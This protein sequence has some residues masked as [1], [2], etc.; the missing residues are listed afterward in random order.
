MT[1]TR[2]VIA[3]RPDPEWGRGQEIGPRNLRYEGAFNAMVLTLGRADPF[4]RELRECKLIEFLAQNLSK[5][6]ADIGRI[7][8]AIQQKQFKDLDPG[9]KQ[10]V[11]DH[12]GVDEGSTSPFLP[13]STI[14]V[15]EVDERDLSSGTT[16]FSVIVPSSPP[17]VIGMKAFSEKF[18]DH[19]E[20]LAQAS[21]HLQ[22]KISDA[23][24]AG[25]V[26][27]FPPQA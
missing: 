26:R 25:R 21:V 18:P 13:T 16:I 15:K 19:G 22:N 4:F 3:N 20:I 27:D 24:R 9:T 12:F 17:A 10:N 23:V 7:E 1:G 2:T 5:A 11:V 6:E 14:A 8:I